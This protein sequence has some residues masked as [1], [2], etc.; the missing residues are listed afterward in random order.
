MFLWQAQPDNY[1]QMSPRIG[2]Y[3]SRSNYV[4]GAK[5][6]IKLSCRICGMTCF[7]VVVSLLDGATKNAARRIF[8]SPLHSFP[9]CAIKPK[10]GLNMTFCASN[11]PKLHLVMIEMYQKLEINVAR[12]APRSIMCI[13][14][15]HHSPAAMT[16][17]C[18]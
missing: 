8:F 3:D 9:P 18:F 1:M 6:P 13:F 16:N 4:S 14:Y 11:W 15:D 7:F 5:S 17:T 10:F 12:N 2:H